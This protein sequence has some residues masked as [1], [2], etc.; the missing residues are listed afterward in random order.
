MLQFIAKHQ[1]QVAG[2]VS[3][4]DRLVLRGSLRRLSY[5]AGMMQYLWAQQVLLKDFAAHVEAVSQAVKDASLAEAC[6]TGRPVQFVRTAHTSKEDLARGIATRDGI[7]SGLVCVLTAVEPCWSYA[8]FR[9]RQSQH[10]RL[11]PR[12]RKC[13]FIDHYRIHPCVGL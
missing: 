1:E 4:F 5:V 8:L 11:L 12:L 9:D 2:V 7:T 6:A 10:V 13:L 3:G